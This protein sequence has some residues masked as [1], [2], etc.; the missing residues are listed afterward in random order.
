MDKY[1]V[2]GLMSLSEQQPTYPFPYPKQS[3][4]NKLRVTVGLGEGKV[5]SCPD[6]DI[7]PSKLYNGFQVNYTNSCQVNYTMV[8]NCNIFGCVS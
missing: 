8:V 6:T 7:D 4:D 1:T 2:N 3:T 5:H